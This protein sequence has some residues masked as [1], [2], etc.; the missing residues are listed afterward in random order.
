MHDIW[1]CSLE[2]GKGSEQGTRLGKPP[3]SAAGVL[4]EEDA[5]WRSA[6]GK[7]VG[8][9]LMA[10]EFESS[11]GAPPAALCCGERDSWVGWVSLAWQGWQCPGHRPLLPFSV[12]LASLF[13]PQGVKPFTV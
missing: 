2:L 9:G 3:A 11:W 1:T 10:C 6:P 7:P 8:E 12:S 13:V 4:G 5:L